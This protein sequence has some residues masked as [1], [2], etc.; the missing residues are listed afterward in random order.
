[1]YNRDTRDLLSCT[2]SSKIRA[3]ETGRIE[4]DQ[5]EKYVYRDTRYISNL[6]TFLSQTALTDDPSELE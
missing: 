4:L 3:I 1:M 2:H 6:F 5:G